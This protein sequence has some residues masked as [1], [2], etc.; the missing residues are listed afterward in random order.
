MTLR[1]RIYFACAAL[2]VIEF[3]VLD[4]SLRLKAVLETYDL[5][6]SE[7]ARIII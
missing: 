5:V 6:A 1:S 2:P 4:D 7:Q 3:Q